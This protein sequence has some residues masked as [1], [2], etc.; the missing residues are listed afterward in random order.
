MLGTKQTG[1]QRLRIADIIRDRCLLPKVQQAA[2]DMLQYYPES[3]AALKRRWIG[4]KEQ[5]MKV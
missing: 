1:M 5:F 2:K 3:I 4:D